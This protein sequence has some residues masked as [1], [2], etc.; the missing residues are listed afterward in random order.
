MRQQNARAKVERIT[1]ASEER[2]GVGWKSPKP[3]AIDQFLKIEKAQSPKSY[4]RF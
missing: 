1:S 4:L 2:I 3:K